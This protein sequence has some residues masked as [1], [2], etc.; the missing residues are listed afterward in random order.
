MHQLEGSILSPKILGDS[1][2]LH[3][4]TVVFVLFAGGELYGFLGLLLAVPI[5]AILKVIVKHALEWL[6]D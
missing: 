2:G 4:L 6:V 3:P 1:V 5:A